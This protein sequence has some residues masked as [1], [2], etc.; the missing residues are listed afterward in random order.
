VLDALNEAFTV[1]KS[2]LLAE[3]TPVTTIESERSGRARF[4]AAW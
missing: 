4:L 2:S 1:P 3:S